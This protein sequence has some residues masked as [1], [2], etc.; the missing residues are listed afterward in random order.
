MLAGLCRPVAKRPGIETSKSAK[1]PGRETSRW[2]T[3]N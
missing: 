3:G 2:Q 1:H